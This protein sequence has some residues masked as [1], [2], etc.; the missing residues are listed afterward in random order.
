MFNSAIG[1]Q[2]GGSLGLF[3]GSLAT[4]LSGGNPAVA[5]MTPGLAGMGA[6]GGAMMGG[7][8]AQNGMPGGAL[9]SACQNCC[10]N[11]RL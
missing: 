8:G 5:A 4:A 7:V 11:C 9:N 6:A 3:G 10:P 1:S 2:L